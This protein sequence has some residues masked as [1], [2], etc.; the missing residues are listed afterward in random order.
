MKSIEKILFPNHSLNDICEKARD[1][2]AYFI[3]KYY[4]LLSRTRGYFEEKMNKTRERGLWAAFYLLI[5]IIAVGILKMYKKEYGLDVK[6][7][8]ICLCGIFLLMGVSVA[9]MVYF[10]LFENRFLSY[11]SKLSEDR[12]YSAMNTEMIHRGFR[13]LT[14]DEMRDFFWEGVRS[15]SGGGYYGSFDDSSVRFEVRPDY[16]IKELSKYFID[17]RFFSVIEDIK[18][19]VAGKKDLVY[20]VS[21]RDDDLILTIKKDKDFEMSR[22]FILQ[23]TDP[24]FIENIRTD[25][26]DFCGNNDV[27]LLFADDFLS[28]RRLFEK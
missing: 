18:K 19:Y 5:E 22:S 7:E 27:D 9:L 16:D 1:V 14:K 8:K 23:T 2:Q 26:I 6:Y 12:I 4:T 17:E 24:A 11:L 10:F 15:I 21:V 28:V 25:S 3:E 20:E 13:D